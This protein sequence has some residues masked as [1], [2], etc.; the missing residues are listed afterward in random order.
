MGVPDPA[1]FKGSEIEIKEYFQK[2]FLNLEKKTK[3]FIE[4]FKNKNFVDLSVLKD[5]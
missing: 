2:T 3:A 1:K 5:L 4:D